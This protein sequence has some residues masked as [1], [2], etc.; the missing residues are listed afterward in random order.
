M[1]AQLIRSRVRADLDGA[2]AAERMLAVHE[3]VRAAEQPG[4]GLIRTVLMQ[5]QADPRQVY[6]LVILGSEE[7]ARA[8]EQDPRRADRLEAARAAMSGL[9]EGTPVFTDLTVLA[10]WAD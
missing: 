5:D 1:W 3:E 9:Y 2:E 4:S 10:E 6:A 8:R 7:Q